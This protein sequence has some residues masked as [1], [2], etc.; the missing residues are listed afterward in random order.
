MRNFKL[1]FLALAA[2]V[3]VTTGC[4]REITGEI[5]HDDITSENC[6]TCHDG[7]L[8][9]A[10]GEWD[11]SIHASGNNVDYTNRGG[12]DC[13]KCH[14][15]EG[16]VQFLETGTLPEEPFS[17]V[18]TI[19]CFTCHDPHENAT[20][21]LRTTAAV[22]LENGDVFD[23]GNGNLC[24]ACHHSR[25]SADDITTDQSVNK[26][27][28]PHYGP[29]GDMVNGSNGWEFPGEGYPF[30][31]SPH[32]TQVRDA[33][34]G[35]HMG[36]VRTHDGN[37]IGGHSFNMV[38]LED[39]TITM[40]AFCDVAGCHPGTSGLDFTADQDYDNNGNIEGFQTESDGLADTLR[41][42]LVAQ[43][44]IDGADYPISGTIADSNK[45]GALYNFLNY[46]KDRS[47]GVHN[48]SYTRSLLEASIDYL[49]SNPAPP[50]GG[51]YST[52]VSH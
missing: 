43:G 42:L 49:V 18:S 52:L 3:L 27:W 10:Q 33:C 32:A 15:Q 25:K 24:V 11:N 44:L 48:F 29:Q 12:S 50:G 9:Q 34:A 21:A 26:Y 39:S 8:D 45:A 22:T 13:T 30:A 7:L 14:D 17:T 37:E 5:K 38:A 46:V 20:M 6:F 23:H 1:L 40:D 2:L 47:R 41:V 4:D 51:I 28:G 19:G 35:C 31:S 16:F 36:Q